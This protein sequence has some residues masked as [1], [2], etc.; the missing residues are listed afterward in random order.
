[1]NQPPTEREIEQRAAFQRQY[2]E[3]PPKATMVPRSTPYLERQLSRMIEVAGLTPEMRIL[4]VGCGMGRHLLP[5]LD[6]GFRIEGQDLSPVLL[7]R[8]REYAGDRPDLVLHAGDIL[9]PEPAW[10]G[11][12]DAVIGFFVLHHLH[13]VGGCIGAMAR[14]LRPGGRMAFIEPNP[15]NPLFHVQILITPRMSYSGERSLLKMRR[16]VVLKAME[17]AALET[18]PIHRFGFFPRFVTN[19]RGGV[20]FEALMERVPFWRPLLPFQIFVGTRP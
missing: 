2:F 3:G 6:R 15:R 5:L 9:S 19:L 1:M 16:N 12:F 11:A 13:D 18:G 17:R 4:E 10:V 8:A 20:W 14:L 7:E